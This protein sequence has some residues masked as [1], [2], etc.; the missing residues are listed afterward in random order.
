MIN[1]ILLLP[2]LACKIFIIICSATSNTQVHFSIDNAN[3]LLPSQIVTNISQCPKLTPRKVP[4]KS[5]HDLRV[6]DIE[7]IMALGDS[8]TAGFGAKEQNPK[9]PI[10]FHKFDENRGV[11]FVM[12]GDPGAVT[13]ANFIKYYSPLLKGPSVGDH[14]V[15]LCY[16]IVCPPFQYK[17]E[18]DRLNAAQSGMMASN[19]TMELIYLLKQLYKEPIQDVLKSYKYLNLFIGSNDICLRCS[20]KLPWLSIEQFENYLLTTLEIIREKIPNTIINLLGVFNVSQVY[21]LTRDEKYCRLRRVIG[22]Y[23]CSCAYMPGALGDLNRKKM[24]E[25]AM[26][27]NK[28]IQNVV[29]YYASKHSDSF[30]VMYQPFD[31]DLLTFPVDGLS[32]LDCFHPSL[33]SHE[34]IAK[35]FW[36]NLVLPSSKRGGPI[37]WN[38]NVGIRCFE[39]DDRINTKLT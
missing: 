3:K 32:S 17:P 14:L 10:D 2:L 27:Y 19:L 15:E 25:T 20:N 24:D 36:N 9:K 5:V 26:E 6:D 35:I 38:D 28:A 1:K 21:E 18:Q 4:P 7:I 33:K 37:V 12:G 30:A 22:D 13:I 23:E 29:N 34:F 16:G 31:L 39:D 8:I 11:S